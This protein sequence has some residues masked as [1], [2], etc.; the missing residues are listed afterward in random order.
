MRIELTVRPCYCGA[1]PTSEDVG[2]DRQDHRP[3]RPAARAHSPVSA[4]CHRRA[5]RGVAT[6]V[7]RD[8]LARIADHPSV[9]S[10]AHES[11]QY[12]RVL[13]AGASFQETESGKER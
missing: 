9:T 6:T 12:T 4:R 5:V 10:V 8:D 1:A 11:N 13:L 7:L 3:I 2:V